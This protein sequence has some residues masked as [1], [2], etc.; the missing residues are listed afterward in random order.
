MTID[1]RRL[2]AAIKKKASA[3]GSP[4]VG[5]AAL[6]SIRNV[7][8]HQSNPETLR[9]FD[10][11]VFLVL[12]L[13]HAREKPELD[14]W[15]GKWGTPGNSELRRIGTSLAHWLKNRLGIDARDLPYH[16]DKGGIFLKEAAVA[17]G[18]GIIGRNNLL[19]TP[20]YGANVRLRAVF[21]EGDA[22]ALDEPVRF[23]PCSGCPAPCRA[24]CP[25]HAFE[26]DGYSRR[27]CNVQMQQDE[28]EA[29]GNGKQGRKRSVI[30]Y[31]RACEWACPVS[32]GFL[33]EDR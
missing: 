24:A 1:S 31:C 17:A 21:L 14:W 10:R 5:I 29:R 33:N 30:R 23:D 6:D 2:A 22:P 15:D 7:P 4:L 32:R 13:E 11:G 26:G 3:L 16:V 27:R 8:S 18:L 28:A 25:Q 19:I 20:A 12:A 9:P